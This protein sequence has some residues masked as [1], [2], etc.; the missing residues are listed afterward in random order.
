MPSATTTTSLKRGN[1][2]SSAP[3]GDSEDDVWGLEGDLPSLAC[4]AAIELDHLTRN[5]N[6]NLPAVRQL[7]SRLSAD[8]S[9][10]D[11]SSPHVPVA[12]G[13]MRRAIADSGL[14]YPKPLKKVAEI[15]GYTGEIA[16]RLQTLADSAAQ[17]GGG[18]VTEAENLRDYC[19]ALS[20][21]A[22]A[23]EPP[24]YKKDPHSPTGR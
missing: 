24:L 20:R 15:L 10:E 14:A 7:A 18:D 8:A 16:R 5:R 19:L 2:M 3:T 1:A 22:A 6:G 4:Q 9:E 13:V 23:T 21:I 17:A 11:A 12:V